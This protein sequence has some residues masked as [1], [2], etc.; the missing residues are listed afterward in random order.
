MAEAARVTA[1]SLAALR[2]TL[3]IIRLPA[4]YSACGRIMAEAVARNHWEVVGVRAQTP[5]T[6]HR[7][8]TFYKV[9]AGEGTLDGKTDRAVVVHSS[10]QEQRRQQHLERE[11]QAS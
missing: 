6:Q 4:P 2:D 8:G 9:A 5:P 11:S 3:G 1:D 10:R 7:P